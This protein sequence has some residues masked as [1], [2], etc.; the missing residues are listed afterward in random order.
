MSIIQ[1]LLTQG[2]SQIPP[3]EY[4][5]V[6][7]GGGGGY[8]GGGGG[9]GGFLTG[10]FSGYTPIIDISVGNGGNGTIGENTSPTNGGN[11]II[12][13]VNLSVTAIGGGAGSNYGSNG[14][15]GGSGGGGAPTDN[16]PYTTSG[17]SGTSGQGYSGG[18]GNRGSP[19]YPGG[20]G[21]GGAGGAGTDKTSAF[22]NA[23]NGGNGV[24]SNFTGTSVTYAGGGGGG[25]Y[26]DP[27]VALVGGGLGG[28]GGGGT[29]GIQIGVTGSVYR[30]PTPG[31]DGLGG[32][33][34]AAG[35]NQ[36]GQRGGSGVII[37]KYSIAYLPAIASGSVT[38]TTDGS[39][40]YYKWTSGTGKLI[41]T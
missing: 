12:T 41:F 27:S 37:I 16:F 30:S 22:A 8:L 32:G 34:G 5:I 6:G 39:Y 28:S 18:Y 33:G 20:G 10:S 1:T 35:N 3:I 23:G 9:A 24:T 26:Y 21:G 2:P 29:G 19:S 17:G 25:Q 4:L 15:S 11:S 36:N 13:G 7:G 38:Y 31:T 40:R 14:S